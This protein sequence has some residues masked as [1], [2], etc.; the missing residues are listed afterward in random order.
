MNIHSIA[1]YKILR[2]ENL[3]A[4]FAMGWGRGFLP[5][6]SVFVDSASIGGDMI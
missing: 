4:D 3:P 5:Q 1:L 6:L 2:Q